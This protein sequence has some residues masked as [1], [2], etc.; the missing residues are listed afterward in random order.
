MIFV[1][2]GAW[3]ALATLTDVDHAAAK[4]FVATISEPLVT[5]DYI[6]DEAKCS[7]YS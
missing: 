6:V 7:G 2:T 1:D 3:Y 5:S 4:A